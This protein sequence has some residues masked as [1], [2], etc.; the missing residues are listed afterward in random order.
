M[1]IHV[2]MHALGMAVGI[3]ICTSIE[4]IQAT[5]SQDVDLQRL[6]MYIISGWPHTKDEV[7]HSIQKYWLIRH[8][9]AMINGI[10]LKGK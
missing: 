2:T 10:A 8:E 4:D 5:T 3:P 6:K 9:L 7:E 1:G